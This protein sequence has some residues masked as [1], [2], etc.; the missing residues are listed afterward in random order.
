MFRLMELTT[1]S[2]CSKNN[3]IS[4]NRELLLTKLKVKSPC[5]QTACP[6]VDKCPQMG[7]REPLQG[8]VLLLRTKL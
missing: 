5:R 3:T 1:L 2:N 7:L 6:L 8:L 4:I